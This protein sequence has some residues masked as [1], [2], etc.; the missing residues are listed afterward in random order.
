MPAAAITGH[1]PDQ[2]KPRA[3]IT[4]GIAF[5]GEQNGQLTPCGCAKPMMGG[6]P[7]RSSYL[8]SLASTNVLIPVENG[9][10]VETIGRQNELKAETTIEA[11]NKMG[12]A[13]I[14]LGEEEFL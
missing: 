12:Y 3:A 5:T 9:D 4:L 11:L 7:R 8:K 6:L 2:P 13:A 1:T 14:N 10:I